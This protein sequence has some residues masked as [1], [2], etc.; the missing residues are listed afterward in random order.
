MS[1]YQKHYN[2]VNYVTSC[3]FIDMINI[4]KDILTKKRK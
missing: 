1:K 4:Y 2:K 3:Q